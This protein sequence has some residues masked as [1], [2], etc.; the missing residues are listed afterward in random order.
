MSLQDFY[1]DK[2]YTFLAVKN[3]D[4][5]YLPMRINI[6]FPH[7]PCECTHFEN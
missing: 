4:S 3:D 6:I 7:L 2:Y 1:E 5:D